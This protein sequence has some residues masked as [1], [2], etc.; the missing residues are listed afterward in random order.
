VVLC[1][2][3]RSCNR[4]SVTVFFWHERQAIII[5]LVHVDD[6]MIAVTS[7]TLIADFKAWILEHVDI[8]DLGK[9]HWLLGIEIKCN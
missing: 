1:E 8:T 9:L 4:F 6:C 5:V 2:P 7:I 3:E